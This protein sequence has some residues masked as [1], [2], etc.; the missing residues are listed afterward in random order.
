M[1]PRV[2]SLVREGPFLPRAGRL[3]APSQSS[4][5]QQ[6]EGGKKQHVVPAQRP[7]WGV[8]EAVRSCFD[9]LNPTEIRRTARASIRSNLIFDAVSSAFAKYFI[10]NVILLADAL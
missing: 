8:C 5:C 3:L 7:G 2:A 9:I 6:A 1:T 10:T 4:A